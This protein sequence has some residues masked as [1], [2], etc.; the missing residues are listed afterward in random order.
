MAPETKTSRER[1]WMLSLVHLGRWVDYSDCWRGFWPHFWPDLLGPENLTCSSTV[2]GKYSV[3]CYPGRENKLVPIYY[4]KFKHTKLYFR[5]SIHCP[6]RTHH[7][8]CI[9]VARR[10][11][12]KSTESFWLFFV[13][14]FLIPLERGKNEILRNSQDFSHFLFSL[15]L[16]PVVRPD[17]PIF[18]DWFIC[19][20]FQP[21]Y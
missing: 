14:V 16:Q 3:Q 5:Y 18:T 2:T 11:K 7:S 19:N 21:P 6:V 20:P 9:S 1:F 17:G 10:G 12:K 4:S 15:R 8:V 13:L